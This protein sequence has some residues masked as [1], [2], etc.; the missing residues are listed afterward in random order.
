M[1]RQR[2]KVSGDPNAIVAVTGRSGNFYCQR[3]GNEEQRWFYQY[4]CEACQKFCWYCRQ[5]VGF[6]MMT[7]CIKIEVN[8]SE[9]QCEVVRSVWNGQLSEQQ[10][11]AS[12]LVKQWIKQAQTGMI[13]AVCGAGKTE[14]MFAGIAA[15]LKNQ[16]R[17]CWATPRSDVVKELHPRLES[18]FQGIAIASHYQNSQ[19]GKIDAQLVIATTH[20]LIRYYQAFDCIII[21]EVDAFP[22]TIDKKLT[23]FAQRA[24]KP[25]GNFI[26]LTATPSKKLQKSLTK[27]QQPIFQL[28]GRYHRR[29]LP[30]PQ[31]KFWGTSKQLLKNKRKQQKLF[32]KI[33]ELLANN[34]VVMVFVP[35][36]QI[37]MTI[38]Q[39]FESYY[40]QQCDFVYSSDSERKQKVEQFRQRTLKVLLTTTI[41]ERGV[42]IDLCEVIIIDA[43]HDVFDW[44]ALVQMSGRVDRKTADSD[45]CVW[46]IA[47]TQ[48][49]AMKIAIKEIKSCNTLA[50]QR[51][52]IS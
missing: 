34:R 13:Y 40:Q 7:T 25:N 38:Y 48:T 51:G 41:L 27:K 37:G 44:A 49:T 32:A 11:Q 15:A 35:T 4:Y 42:T 30:V 18:A 9:F 31:I 16:Q 23:R 20:Q 6:G 2:W 12:I 36:I 17:I 1:K 10:T 5:C 45:A 52:I 22:Y 26:Y 19:F 21:D 33:D 50:S 29:P 3:C 24:C 14:M 43:D 8:Q 28:P 39:V 47:Q 46:F